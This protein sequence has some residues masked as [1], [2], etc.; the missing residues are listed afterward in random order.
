MLAAVSDPLPRAVWL[1]PAAAAA[2]C[3]VVW[4]DLDRS[5]APPSPRPSP[6]TPLGPR[7]CSLLAPPP[8]PESSPGLRATP[9]SQPR[10][11]RAGKQPSLVDAPRF[12]G[13][14]VGL[15]L[16]PSSPPPVRRGPLEPIPP[17]TLSASSSSPSSSTA[18]GSAISS[19][20]SSCS[21][22]GSIHLPPVRAS[23]PLPARA[24]ATASSITCDA[25][26]ARMAPECV[27]TRGAATL[28]AASPGKGE[29][30]TD[31]SVVVAE[32]DDTSG[33]ADDDDVVLLL[34]AL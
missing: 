8:V 14:T 15:A 28:K 26:V 9:S 7:C 20:S 27:A 30:S 6:S 10:T 34:S 22:S 29:E 11:T 5:T 2:A 1:R 13:L 32:F 3:A 19:S 33:G 16:P 23:G 17:P 25:V 24:R 12:E 21:S 18:P 4:Y 31:D